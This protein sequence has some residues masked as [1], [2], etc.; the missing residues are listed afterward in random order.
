MA[1][2]QDFSALWQ[3]YFSY[4]NIKDV[5]QSDSKIYAASENAIFSYDLLSNE[6]QTITTINGLSGET[7]ATIHYSN[8]YQLLV[9]GYQN[10]LMEVYFESDGAILTVVDILEKET[11]S[12]DKKRINHLNEYNGSIYISTDYGISVYNLQGL[13]FGDTYFIGAGGSQISVKQTTLFGDVIYAACGNGNGLRKATASNPNIIDYQQW[14]TIANGTFLAIE[15][16]GDRLY[17][18]KSDNVIHEIV[19]DNLSARF[20]YG[21]SP[22]DMRSVADNLVVTVPHRTYVYSSSFNLIATAAPNSEFNTQFTSA[23]IAD[24]QIYI[25][26]QNFGVLKTALENPQTFTVVRPDGPLQNDTFKINA[27]NNEVWA[28]YGDYDVFYNAYPIQSYGISHYVEEQWVNIPYEEVLT[29]K[30]L[31]DISINPFNPQQVFIS[32]YFSGL[33]ELNNGEPTILY[34]QTN[35]GLES[36][37]IGDPNYIDIRVGGSTF[38]RSGL[39]WTITSLLKR[40]LKSIILPP[41]NGNPIVLRKSFQIP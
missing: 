18:I 40:P 19:N 14:T 4:F 36:L 5:T 9:I 41:S 21:E 32:S 20:S 28:T 15:S 1:Q 37:D 12:P 39:L 35:S 8:D 2:A 3:G 23:T 24:G 27:S 30:N 29:A 34:N 6:L 17:T 33:L 31:V 16:V 13:E 38:D 11:I 22:V 26:T 10:G 7:I 25:G